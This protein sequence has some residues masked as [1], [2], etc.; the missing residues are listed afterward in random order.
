MPGRGHAHITAEPDPSALTWARA[1]QG[2]S[3][4]SEGH[5]GA[6][7]RRWPAARCRLLRGTGEARQQPR[8]M[9]FAAVP[10]GGGCCSS[11]AGKLSPQGCEVAPEPCA[12]DCA[13]RV[14]YPVSHTLRP[15]PHMLHLRGC[16][17]SPTPCTPSPA[18]CTLHASSCIVQPCPAPFILHPAPCTPNPAPRTLHPTLCTPPA[19]PH[20]QT[21]PLASLYPHPLCNPYLEPPS[22]PY[23]LTPHTQKPTC[24]HWAPRTRT[25]PLPS[26][27]HTCSSSPTICSLLLPTLSPVLPVQGVLEGTVGTSGRAWDAVVAQDH[28]RVHQLGASSCPPMPAGS[29][30]P[31]LLAR[32]MPRG[33][34]VRCHP[35]GV[36]GSPTPL[37]TAPACVTCL[38]TMG[39]P[40]PWGCCCRSL[41]PRAPTARCQACRRVFPPLWQT[42]AAEQKPSV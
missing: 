16:S 14:L 10:T 18:P 40:V 34:G 30:A 6:R 36:T 37:P 33:L 41:S 22:T 13:P 17:C 39:G 29:R 19:Q 27:P 15:K 42:R 31:S 4:G 21:L 11:T 32:T 3:A 35:Q 26:T 28:C 1:A 23:S 9:L 5:G 7:G 38:E 24:A 25:P 12:P 8:P 20:N 2:G